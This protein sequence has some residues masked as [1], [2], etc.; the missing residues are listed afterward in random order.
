MRA[1]SFITVMYTVR[2]YMP[3]VYV[4]V[5]LLI[6]MLHKKIFEMF[7][8]KFLLVSTVFLLSNYTRGE[9]ISTRFCGSHF[10]CRCVF[11]FFVK[12]CMYFDEPFT[13]RKVTSDWY[14]LPFLFFFQRSYPLHD[15]I[16]MSN[17]SDS[18]SLQIFIC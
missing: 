3:C 17:Q 8:L 11:R 7:N 15:F 16:S 6:N 10:L 5:L 9:Y 12:M 13:R 4:Y 1:K 14:G 18:D 2:L